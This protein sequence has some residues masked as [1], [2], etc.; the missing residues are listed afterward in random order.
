MRAYTESLMNY[1]GTE[2]Y[3]KGFGEGERAVVLLHGWG[4]SSGAMDGAYRYLA[5]IG[6]TVYSVDFPGFGKSDF[7]PETWGIYDYADC[8]QYMLSEL[9]LNKPLIV[10]HSFGG[11]VALI[12]GARKV[13]SKLV[14]TDAAGLKPRI[15]LRKK[16]AIY[17][18]KRAKRKGREPLNAG[19]A[20]YNALSPAMRKVFVRVVNTHLDG[21]LPKIDVPTL[22]FWGKDDR[23]TPPY[24]AKRLN[25]GICGSGLIMMER[26]GHFAYAERSDVFNAALGVFS[27]EK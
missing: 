4:A 19:S 16:W 17:K 27:A 18:Y 22:L 1:N 25:K 12:L 20:D 10:G 2:I 7:P 9:G 24:M 14:L 5:S 21:L 8:I 15:S 26:A 11:R 3:Y 6:R 13:A 23:D